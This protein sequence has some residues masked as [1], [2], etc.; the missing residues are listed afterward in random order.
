MFY[1]VGREGYVY[2]IYVHLHDFFSAEQFVE[3]NRLV[4]CHSVTSRAHVKFKFI[5]NLLKIHALDLITY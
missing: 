1:K 4:E 3:E 5:L 2:H